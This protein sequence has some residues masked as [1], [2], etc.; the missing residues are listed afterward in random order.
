MLALVSLSNCMDKEKRTGLKP[1]PD[2][3]KEVLNKAQWQTLKGTEYSDWVLKFV[4]GPL[5]HEPV[6]VMHNT[7]DN[8][9]GVLEKDGS[10]NM[11]P[12]IKIRDHAKL[13][14]GFSI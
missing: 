12:N 8:R 4:R 14:T 5:S 13:C 3:L 9:I 11:R 2:D 10:I 1:I 7:Q 6:V